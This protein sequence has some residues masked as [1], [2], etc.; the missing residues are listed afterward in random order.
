MNVLIAFLVLAFVFW[1]FLALKRSLFMDL[2][3]IF[4]AALV[5]LLLVVLLGILLSA[6]VIFIYLVRI[7]VLVLYLICWVYFRVK[8]WC[9]IIITNLDIEKG[10]FSS[11]ESLIVFI[12]I[13]GV[14]RGFWFDLRIKNG[15]MS[16]VDIL[17]LIV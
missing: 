16:L 13:A 15:P 3:L 9:C 10:L 11:A 14:Y 7:I 5:R 2:L 6:I 17:F 12:M 8:C 1:M 4:I